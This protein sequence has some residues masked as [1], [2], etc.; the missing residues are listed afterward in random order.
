MYYPPLTI[1]NIQRPQGIY[2]NK[3]INTFLYVVNI[4]IVIILLNIIIF[5]IRQAFII[6][7]NYV[8]SLPKYY[9]TVEGYLTSDNKLDC[10]II[11]NAHANRSEQ[12]FKF[13]LEAVLHLL[14]EIN[15]KFPNQQF[16]CMLIFSEVRANSEL[17]KI[18][19]NPCFFNYNVNCPITVNE[20]YN[21]IK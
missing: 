13:M 3:M 6:I 21:L 11:R 16:T 20:L 14:A 9:L 18:I 8:L 4:V 5:I 19:A 1:H 15:S 10:L 17:H 2:N 7:K 12:G